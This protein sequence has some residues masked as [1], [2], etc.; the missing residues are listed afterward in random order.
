[1]KI[2]IV[3][4]MIFITVLPVEGQDSNDQ[5]LNDQFN[6]LKEN[7]EDYRQYK[8]IEKT[9]LNEFWT[10]VNDSI[11]KLEGTIQSLQEENAQKST[12]IK[13][14][15][16]QIDENR[17]EI[18]DLMT[19]TTTISVFGL[20]V[21]KSTY[22]FI[23]FFIAGVLVLV[24]FFLVYQFKDAR[25]TAK[26]KVRDYENLHREFEDYKRNALEKQMKLRRELQTAQNKLEE[27][28]KK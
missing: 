8:V 2:W 22:I 14:L 23:S 12:K 28:S 3:F 11:D 25:R 10:I 13:S 16:D 24:I 19:Q 5:E 21:D 17:N 27:A 7:S 4:V 26:V 20:P 1:M 6:E 18:D 9:K 15:N